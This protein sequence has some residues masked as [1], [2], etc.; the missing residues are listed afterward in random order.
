MFSEEHLTDHKI[1]NITH[2]TGIIKI[3]NL[4]MKHF[5]IW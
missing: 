2:N 4:R 3:Y 1:V 5:L